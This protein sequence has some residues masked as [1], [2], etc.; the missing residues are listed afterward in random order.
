MVSP[1]NGMPDPHVARVYFDPAIA[2]KRAQ[3]DGGAEVPGTQHGSRDSFEGVLTGRR[4]DY[5]D[6]PWKWVELGEL[7][8]KPVGFEDA[9]VWCDEQY[10]FVRES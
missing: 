4:L 6:P 5:G 10:V 2:G 8:E 9:F 3:A 1:S 7:T